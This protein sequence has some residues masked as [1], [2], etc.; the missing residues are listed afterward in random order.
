[1]PSAMIMQLNPSGYSHNHHLMDHNKYEDFA[2][3]LLGKNAFLLFHVDKILTQAI[4]QL[5]NMSADI[6]FKEAV[7]LYNEG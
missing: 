4:K 7:R 3:K 6:V 1:M 5:T 2:R